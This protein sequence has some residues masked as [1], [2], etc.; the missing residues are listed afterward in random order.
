M[1]QAA[2]F[3]V[4]LAITSL[5]FANKGE[6]NYT[7]HSSVDTTFSSMTSMQSI[8]EQIRNVAGVSENFEIKE[9]DVLNIEATIRHR[10]KYILYNSSFI[11]SLNSLTKDKWSVIALIAHEMGHHMMGHTNR[12]GGSKPALELE[13]D[14]FAGSVLYK[15]GATLEQSQNVMR[16]IAKADESKTHPGR[17]ARL[18]AIE[19]GWKKAAA[20]QETA[21]T[22]NK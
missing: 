6:N 15:L 2:L 22:A 12:R 18:M 8:L 20:L 19:R 3:I 9:A 7:Q 16:F 11:S 10:K 17:D 21:I 4:L 14:E 5:S 13:A 1:K